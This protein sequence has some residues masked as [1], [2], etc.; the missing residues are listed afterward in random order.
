MKR[1]RPDRASLLA[2]AVFIAPLAHAGI[3]TVTIAQDPG[4]ATS[5]FQ[6]P[7]TTATTGYTIQV[8]DDGTYLN[9][10]EQTTGTGG[11]PFANLYFDTTP[12]T[13]PGSNLGFEFGTDAATYDAF[14]P[15]VTGSNTLI[16]SAATAA[17]IINGDQITADIKIANNFFIENPLSLA[18]PSTP[19]GTDVSLHLSQSF[20]YSV[21]GGGGNYAAPAELGEAIVSTP[22]P[23]PG[24]Y[25]LLGIG[26][27]GL[28]GAFRRK[29]RA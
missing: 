3:N 20:G 23:E 25:G 19:S 22:T 17:F 2:V 21:V 10:V 8:Y 15:G 18:Y 11:L 26:M 9:V 29:T 27:A 24:L 14:I 7:G 12:S 6:A 1:L 5:N 28:V 13:Y 16:G 4:A